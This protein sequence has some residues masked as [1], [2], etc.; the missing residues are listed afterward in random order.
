[1]LFRHS[2]ECLPPLLFREVYKLHQ[3]LRSSPRPSLK[4]AVLFQI[5]P[6]VLHGFG[7][8]VG[9]S[10]REKT[11]FYDDP[12]IRGKKRCRHIGRLVCLSFV[13]SLFAPKLQSCG[14][15]KI[16]HLFLVTSNRV[17]TFALSFV[18]SIVLIDHLVIKKIVLV[19]GQLRRLSWKL[20]IIFIKFL[21]GSRTVA[22]VLLYYNV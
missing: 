11:W 8:L 5:N 3:R 4:R 21:W 6:R 16:S 19:R 13:S 1:M 22:R 14:Q 2:L 7:P 15:G 20:D 9:L 17:V 12:E 10:W 18:T